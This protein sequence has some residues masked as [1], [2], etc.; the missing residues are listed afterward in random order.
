MAS[1]HDVLDSAY[2]RA[3]DTVMLNLH[4]KRCGYALRA[5]VVAAA[6]REGRRFQAEEICRKAKIPEPFTRKILHALVEGGLLVA[7]RGP[8]GGYSFARPPERISL[9]D[10]AFVVDGERHNELCL[11]GLRHCG[12]ADNCPL[13]D[14]AR[15][16]MAMVDE[17]LRHCT[18]A[19]VV[20]RL[21]SRKEVQDPPSSSHGSPKRKRRPS[22]SLE[23]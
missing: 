8:G 9:Y 6:I 14:I 21:K 3:A 17:S 12:G 18:L 1:I 22:S 19:Q 16:S 11:L 20:D 4:S 2:D 10:V 13:R 23:P 5:L 7:H 15:A